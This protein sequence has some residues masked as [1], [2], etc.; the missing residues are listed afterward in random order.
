ML[1][2]RSRSALSFLKSQRLT[3][4]ELICV[5]VNLLEVHG[6]LWMGWGWPPETADGGVAKKGCIDWKLLHGNNL[7]FSTEAQGDQ[8][9]SQHEDF[10][11]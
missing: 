8:V 11:G 6:A 2:Y 10:S 7:T 1:C 4:H 5:Y 3:A 9:A